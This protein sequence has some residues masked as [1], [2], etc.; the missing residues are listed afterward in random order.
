[1]H[2]T[3]IAADGSVT[4]RLDA[5]DVRDL[6]AETLCALSGSA[7]HALHQYLTASQTERADR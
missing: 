7:A 1:M 6:T 4:I 3:A 2:I 5:D